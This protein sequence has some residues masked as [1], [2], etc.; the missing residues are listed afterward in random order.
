MRVQIASGLIAIGS[1]NL[2][3]RASSARW[4][5]PNDPGH[6]GRARCEATMRGAALWYFGALFPASL[7]LLFGSK[8]YPLLDSDRHPV[9]R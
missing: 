7:V 2:L 4:T 8:V 6:Y 5:T 9:V 3:L 1:A